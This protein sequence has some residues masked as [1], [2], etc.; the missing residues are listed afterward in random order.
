MGAILLESIKLNQT[1][2]VL[3]SFG[4]A[5][6][7]VNSSDPGSAGKYQQLG[8]VAAYT[9]WLAD[10]DAVNSTFDGTVR[11]P[12]VQRSDIIKF[13]D[14]PLVNVSQELYGT[15]IPQVFFAALIS[16]TPSC[17]NVGS[18]FGPNTFSTV[19]GY[20]LRCGG[21]IGPVLAAYVRE[22]GKL[23]PGSGFST[24][25]FEVQDALEP[26]LDLKDSASP[27]ILNRALQ[28]YGSGNGTINALYDTPFQA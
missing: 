11:P 2:A 25:L 22:L 17:W 8:K 7:A 3:R 12:A 16:S 18:S 21:R 1:E 14:T 4:E 13:P 20:I 24:S 27:R 26:L 19:D 10:P 28:V 15:G 5:V 9:T 23:V 6:A